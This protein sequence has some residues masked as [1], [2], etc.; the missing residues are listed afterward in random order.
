MGYPQII[1]FNRLSIIKHPFWDPPLVETSIYIYMDDEASE[2]LSSIQMGDHGQATN[3]LDSDQRE[4]MGLV[5]SHY[6]YICCQIIHM[7]F[8]YITS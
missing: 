3:D 5:S 1:H 2:F 6:I 4:I 8:H 7:L